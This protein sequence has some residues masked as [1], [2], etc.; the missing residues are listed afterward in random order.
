M[1]LCFFLSISH[2]LQKLHSRTPKKKKKRKTLL[3]QQQNWHC[4]DILVWVTTTA[5]TVTAWRVTLYLQKHWEPNSGRA[6]NQHSDISLVSS[7]YG[8]P[9]SRG[10][11]GVWLK[12][13]HVR[14][15]CW[16]KTFATGCVVS[17]GVCPRRRQFG[18]STAA[19][20]DC[21]L[22]AASGGALLAAVIRK[23]RRNTVSSVFSF[24]RRKPLMMKGGGE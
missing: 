22:S 5:Q 1:I 23:Q 13:Q 11:G 10:P 12:P 18:S 6:R 8:A 20:L 2:Y 24:G 19:R 21:L 14:L 9:G 4:V 3:L 17:S 7:S 16:A 15:L